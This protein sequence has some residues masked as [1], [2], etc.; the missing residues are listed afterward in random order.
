MTATPLES[1][2]SQFVQ[3]LH[4]DQTPQYQ[5][6]AQLVCQVLEPAVSAASDLI[7]TFEQYHPTS[8]PHPDLGD[9]LHSLCD[10]N[11]GSETSNVLL[12]GFSDELHKAWDFHLT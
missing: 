3:A 7:H 11:S 4:Q 6:V 2:I 5:A 9:F 1:F 8:T 12:G 10:C